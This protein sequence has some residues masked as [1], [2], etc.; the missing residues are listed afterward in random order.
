MLDRT[1]T[2]GDKEL[3]IAALPLGKLRKLVPAFN[4]AARAF[5]LGGVDES[6]LD[7]V[8]VI[9]ASGTGIPVAEL[10]GM[11]GTYVQLMHA[12]EVIAEVCGLKP[13]EEPASGE[14]LP[15]MASPAS[16]PGTPSTQG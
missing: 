8:F 6:S 15:G 4:R 12:V 13:E 3:P 9:L 16:I 14:A 7:D 5:A 2:L 1:I 11:P 10:E